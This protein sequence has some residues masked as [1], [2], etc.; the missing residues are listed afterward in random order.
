MK[1]K[2]TYTGIRVKDLDASVAF[3]TKVLGMKE[4]GRSK[5]EAADG[6]VVNLVTEDDGHMIELNFYAPSSKFYS[7]YVVGDGIDHL[8]FQVED[9]DKALQEAARAGHPTVLDMKG[10]TSRW[11]YIQDPNGIYIE[12]FT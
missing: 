10:K 2:L 3:Y 6:E 7:N 12:L 1:S 9:L 5:V 11:A 8:A 4:V